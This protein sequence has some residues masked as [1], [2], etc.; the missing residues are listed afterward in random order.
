MEEINEGRKVSSERLTEPLTFTAFEAA[1][2]TNG[3][4]RVKFTAEGHMVWVNINKVSK[5]E[6]L[7]VLHEIADVF[8]VE[9]TFASVNTVLERMLQLDKDLE[10]LE[11]ELNLPYPFADVEG[12]AENNSD[13]SES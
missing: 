13:N 3:E 5:K 1:E 12:V 6:V 2:P 4:I 9:I 7:Q 8:H 11:N 10:K